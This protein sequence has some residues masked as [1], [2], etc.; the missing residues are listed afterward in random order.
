MVLALIFTLI[1]VELIVVGLIDIKS[2]KISN[3]WVILNI[4]VS[5]ILHLT[6]SAFYPMTWEVFLFPLGFL[7]GGFIL[8]LWNVM[9]AGDSKFLASLFLIIPVE[10]HFPYFE[11]LVLVTMLTGASLL[12]IKALKNFREMGFFLLTKYWEGIK[13]TIRSRFSYAPVIFIAWILLGFNIWN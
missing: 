12:T 3:K 8:F 6:V 10:Y 1:A 4:V 7:V 11:K 9:G 5:V 13:Q 2:K